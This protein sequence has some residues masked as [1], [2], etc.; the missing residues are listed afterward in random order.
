MVNELTILTSVHVLAA[1]FWVGGAFV[2]NV[3]LTLA[4]RAPEPTPR[5]HTLRLADVLVPYAFLPIA[6]IVF[7][8]GVWMTAEYYDFSEL[9]INLGMIGAITVISLALFYI[10]PRAAR[11]I[12]AIE[13]GAAPPPPGTRNWV[14]IVG[15][16]NLLLLSALVVIMVIKPT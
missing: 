16:F 5:L 15:R 9:W 4:A 12:A 11:A 1:A 3:A 7:G 2:L 8:T 14:P 10:K 6:V 13:S